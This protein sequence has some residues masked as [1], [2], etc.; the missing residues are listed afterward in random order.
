VGDCAL[1]VA[2]GPQRADLGSVARAQRVGAAL[3]A[4]ALPGVQDVVPGM[5]TV[6]VIL[7]RTRP[8]D[9]PGRIRALVRQVA[10]QAAGEVRRAPASDPPARVVVIPVRY[11]GEDG[12]DLEDVACETQLAAAEVVA[13][14]QASE[15]TVLA[16]GFRPGFAFLGLLDPTLAV[17]RRASPRTLVPAGSVGVAGRQTGVYP[18]DAPGGWRLLGRTSVRLF[19]PAAAT[20]RDACLLRPGDLVQ[21]VADPAGS[22]R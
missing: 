11:G 14:H 10:D 17:P 19:D 16:L 13:R 4:A 1:E 21:F 15:Y 3:L 9:D 12:P 8:L 5:R 20:A 7:E 6:L 22:V 18:C 2:V